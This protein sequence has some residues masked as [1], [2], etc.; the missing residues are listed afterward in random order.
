MVIEERYIVFKI[1]DVVRCLSDDDKQ[2]L[3]DIRQKLCEYRQANGKPEQ[4]CVV[5]ESDWPEYEPIWQ[6]IA[7][8]VAAEQA[9]Q[10]D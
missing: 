8:R 6:A 9:A 3:A 10:A 1:S 2:R 5:A 7:D 4:H